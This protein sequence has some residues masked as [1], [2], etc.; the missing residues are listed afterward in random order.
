MPNVEIDDKELADLRKA[1]KDAAKAVA[2]AEA[3]AGQLTE[4]RAGAT[5]LAELEEQAKGWQAERLEAT[6]T[7][8]GIKDAKVRRV[9]Q[10]EFDEQAAVEGGEKDLGKYLA[11][12]QA[13]PADKRPAVL[14]PFLGAPGK[15]GAANPAGPG[16]RTGVIPADSK[17]AKDLEGA[18]PEFTP[19][20]IAPR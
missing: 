15:P 1:A 8:A 4:A 13:L 9:F 2:Q 7:G 17:G 16:Q 5:R 12:V 18:P 19:E 6:F 3:L 10:L 11:S 14:A 20:S